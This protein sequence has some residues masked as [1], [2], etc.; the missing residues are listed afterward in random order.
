MKTNLIKFTHQENTESKNLSDLELKKIVKQ[1]EK[2]I[3]V[4][5]NKLAQQIVILPVGLIGA[6]KTTVIKPICDKLGLVR[7]SADEIRYILKSN[8]FNYLRIAEIIEYVVI[9]Y[10]SQ[11][12]SIGMDG[13]NVAPITQK[14]FKKY[15]RQYKCKLFWIHISPSE[16]FIINKLKNYNHTWLFKNSDEAIA[17]YKN[18]K[19]LHKQCLS[20]INFY[21]KIDTS[22]NNLQ[23]QIEKLISKLN[24]DLN[25]R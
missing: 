8:G 2:N 6:G 19:L 21:Y 4:S 3:N 1:Y 10:L 24:I 17:K 16:K 25:K 5:K 23:Q 7:V 20:S 13:D 11:G 22:K 18:R 15:A 12:Y 9:D 14:L